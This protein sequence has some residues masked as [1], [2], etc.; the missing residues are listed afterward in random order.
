MKK[1]TIQLHLAEQVN[2]KSNTSLNQGLSE[3]KPAPTSRA[4]AY[5]WGR[6]ISVLVFFFFSLFFCQRGIAETLVDRVL[7]GSV[8]LSFSFV[9]L[10]IFFSCGGHQTDCPVNLHRA[11]RPSILMDHHTTAYNSILIILPDSHPIQVPAFGLY[12]HQ[13]IKH[14]VRRGAPANHTSVEDGPIGLLYTSHNLRQTTGP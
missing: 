13:R 9:F 1:I 2:I 14:R 4:P 6:M 3:G 10:F 5:A 11:G 12:P 8:S 7:L